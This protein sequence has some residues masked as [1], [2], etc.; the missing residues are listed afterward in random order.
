MV[1]AEVIGGVRMV[2]RYET[3]RIGRFLASRNARWIR[4][5]TPSSSGTRGSRSRTRPVPSKDSTQRKTM[6]NS[7]GSTRTSPTVLWKP[8]RDNIDLILRDY[9]PLQ[10][11]TPVEEL[12]LLGIAEGGISVGMMKR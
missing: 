9:L 4:Y 12:Q 7:V 8:T 6:R 10:R 2:R 11:G 5:T 3:E 1:R